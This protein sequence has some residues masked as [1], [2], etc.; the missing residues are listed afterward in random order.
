LNNFYS[1]KRY[2]WT[3]ICFY[4]KIIYQKNHWNEEERL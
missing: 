4:A 2:H 1:K 3:K